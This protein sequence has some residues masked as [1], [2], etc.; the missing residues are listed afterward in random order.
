MHTVDI[1][2][3][4]YRPDERLRLLLR[5][6]A[7]QS[8]PIRHIHI[9][10]TEQKYWRDG[11]LPDLG[12]TALEITHISLREF[13]HGGTRAMGAEMSSADF[14]MFMTQDAVPA[15]SFLVEELLKPF[16]S[17][18]TVA[19]SYA[20]QLPVKGQSDLTEEFARS[21]NYPKESRIKRREDIKT[22]GIKAFFCSDVCAMYRREAY[23][24][25]GGF[26]SPTI[27]NEDMIFAAD[28]LQKGMGVAY[29][30]EAR[31][32]H[33]HCYSGK[34]L[35]SR[36]FDMGVSQRLYADRFSVVSSEKEGVRFVLAAARK[37]YSQGGLRPVIRLFY[38]SACKYAG[39]FL[40]KHYRVLPKRVVRR[41][42]ACKAYWDKPEAR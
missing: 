26:V 4:T 40:G 23:F 31:V 8:Y 41:L 19:V 5:G 10:N 16:F 33:S 18:R 3:P 15:D 35:I 29:C 14:F 24:K 1:I 20:R 32:Y 38:N 42:S 2:I 25:V 11:L 34:Q 30:A 39:Y 12:Q 7:R 28:A 13:D 37:L 9:I 27:F 21:F 17:D 22:M 36:N 6:I